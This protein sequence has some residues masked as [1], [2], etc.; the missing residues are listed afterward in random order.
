MRFHFKEKQQQQL[1]RR[2]AGQQRARMTRSIHL[3]R[4][5][6]LTVLLHCPAITSM[7]LILSYQC[8]NRAVDDQSR[9]RTLLWF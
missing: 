6:V 7:T 8:S 1:T 5:D 3:H 4:H 2:N 9:S